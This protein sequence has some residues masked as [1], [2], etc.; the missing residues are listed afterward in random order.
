MVRKLSYKIMIYT[1]DE[2]I[3]LVKKNINVFENRLPDRIKQQ[4]LSR[5]LRISQ[6]GLFFSLCNP[7]IYHQLLSAL[8]T[9]KLYNRARYFYKAVSK[10]SNA[11]R[12]LDQKAMVSEIIAIGYYF[13]KFLKSDEI[14]VEWERPLT[15]TNKVMDISLLG[16]EVPINI[17]VTIKEFNR[18]HNE[19]FE[20]RYKTKV[21]IEKAIER[22]PN[23]KYHY[24]F[25]L[26]TKE[27]QQNITTEFTESNIEGFVNFVLETRMIGLGKYQYFKNGKIIASVEIVK[28]N[29][30]RTEF[31]SCSDIWSGF[32][33]DENR[34]KNRIVDKAREQLPKDEV[35]FV[36]IPNLGG[37]DE[38]DYQE[39][40]LGKEQ[41]SV[42]QSGIY[43]AGRKSDGSIHIIS[44]RKYSPVH[45]LIWSEW[46]YSRRNVLANPLLSINQ[47]IIDI[48]K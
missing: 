14:N 31:A 45:G 10:L 41:W 26:V 9:I 22:L 2:E 16:L 7:Q 47:D 33:N 38:I 37:F 25:S 34:I 4:L 27:D 1:R 5:H 12:W 23:Q 44:E 19:Y 18:S 29:K 35:N 21:F 6:H 48:I 30:L 13:K 32:L 11:S 28:L 8:E 15:N 36:Y 20:L 40:F 24:L 17:E 39:A 3:E 42:N 46:D 43:F